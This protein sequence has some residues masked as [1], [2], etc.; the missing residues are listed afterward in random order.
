MIHPVKNLGQVFTRKDSIDLMLSLSKSNGIVLEPSAGQ[1]DIVKA[2]LEI[3]RDV[4]AIE[5]DVTVSKG[6]PVT[7]MDFFDYPISNKFLTIIGNPPY[8]KYSNII[9]MTKDKLCNTIFDNRTNLY[10]HFIYKCIQHLERGG[11]LIFIT[12]KDFL[13]ATSGIPLNKYMY[14]HGTITHFYDLSGENTFDKASPDACIWRYELDNFTRRTRTNSGLLRYKVNGGFVNFT[15]KDYCVKMSDIATIKVG[16]VSGND[17]LFASKEFNPKIDFVCSDTFSSGRLKKMHYY[18][19]QKTLMPYKNQLM[20]RKIRKFDEYTWHQW[21]RLCS[22]ISNP[23]VYVN[24]RTRKDNPFFTNNCKFFDGS[25]LG[26]FPK[27]T[28]I[29]LKEFCD[30]LNSVDWNDLG[31]KYGGRYIFQQRSL[32]NIYLPKEFEKY[33]V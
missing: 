12:P 22:D 1:G 15:N 6:Y 25:I 3:K 26:I 5:L 20:E 9:S 7:N 4:K 16:A 23:R 27:K 30:A 8:V 33:K 28:N 14:E 24:S 11:E 19:N 18:T 32:E 31:F 17:E 21:G 13:K 2:I 29:D 10:I